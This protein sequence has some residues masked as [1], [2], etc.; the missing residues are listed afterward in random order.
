MEIEKEARRRL[1]AELHNN[2]LRK[3]VKMADKNLR[4]VREAAM[5]SYFF[6][7]FARKPETCVRECDQVGLYQHLKTINLERKRGHSW[8]YAKDEDGILLR[9]VELSTNVDSDGCQLFS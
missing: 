1:R 7:A 9:D 8:A 2:N 5:L 3:P 6:W 4:D